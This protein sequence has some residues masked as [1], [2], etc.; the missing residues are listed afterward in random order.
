VSQY[1]LF[2]YVRDRQLDYVLCLWIYLLQLLLLQAVEG[3]L[4]GLGLV[5]VSSSRLLP[6]LDLSVALIN[7]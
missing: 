5:Q 7:F 1:V 6:L 2:Y 4:E 3:G